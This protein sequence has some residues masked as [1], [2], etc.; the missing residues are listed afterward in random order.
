M[1]PERITLK[2]AQARWDKIASSIMLVSKKAEGLTL[3][4]IDMTTIFAG[5]QSM[6]ASAVAKE[7]AK[8]IGAWEPVEWWGRNTDEGSIWQIS[9]NTPFVYVIN[10]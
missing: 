5:R 2:Q 9:V 7:V 4:S 8:I 1:R 3:P 10:T 6:T